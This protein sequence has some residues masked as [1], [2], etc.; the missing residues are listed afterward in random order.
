VVE[1]RRVGLA[2]PCAASLGPQNR[3][4]TPRI[5]PLSAQTL[6]HFPALLTLPHCTAFRTSQGR[7]LALIG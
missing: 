6:C 7:S 1:R 2:K 4:G 5:S 3:I